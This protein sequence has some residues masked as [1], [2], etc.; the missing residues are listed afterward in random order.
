MGDEDRDS[1]SRQ[2]RIAEYSSPTPATA[3]TPAQPTSN[4]E[5]GSE[6]AD[7]EATG[8]TAADT[9]GAKL[10]TDA[11]GGNETSTTTPSDQSH[12]Q[13]RTNERLVEQT[14][15]TTTP[16]RASQ[17]QQTLSAELKLGFTDRPST[18]NVTEE[19][20]EARKLD[21]IITTGRYPYVFDACRFGF[22][23]GHREE[24]NYQ[25]S[26]DE[27]SLPVHFLDNDYRDS[28]LDR[29]VERVHEYQPEVA[30]I[31]DI[32]DSGELDRHLN[33][34][35]SLW[36]EYPNMELVIVPKTEDVLHEIPDKFVAGYPN[37]KSDIKGSDIA[38]I[39]EWRSISNGIHILG[40]TPLE[41]HDV[42]V[43]LTEYYLAGPSPANIVGLDSNNMW[44]HAQT[45]GDYVDA[46]GGWHRNL[47]S[48]GADGEYHP[49]RDL[50]IYSLLNTKHYWISKGVWP[51]ETPADLALRESL[52]TTAN[53]GR[54]GTSKQ[55][56]PKSDNRDL[57]ELAMTP[58]VTQ[59]R[60][61]SHLYRTDETIAELIEPLS[62]VSVMLDTGWQPDGTLTRKT[63]YD[64]P[65]KYRLHT[66]ACPGCGANVTAEPRETAGA[67][68]RLHAD[69]ESITVKLTSY[70]HYDNENRNHEESI[71]QSGAERLT[72]ASEWGKL[73]LFCSDQC[74]SSTE[75][76]GQNQIVRDREMQGH[77]AEGE[78]IATFE[79]ELW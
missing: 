44:N 26:P 39:Q 45:W 21:W 4:Q 65:E 58:S 8:S 76:R 61:N 51:G 64:I 12:T 60:Q 10:P 56:V 23:I 32:Y 43:D 57:R 78:V 27:V 16:D 35:E 24:S 15:Q 19:V 50:M 9:E 66:T 68:S 3:Q 38:S 18:P 47:R 72:P 46:T 79:I 36:A 5:T 25:W 28:D 53:L 49:K 6:T 71:A 34:A 33:A 29:F 7:G 67:R 31:G 17:S 77:P 2:E 69:Q 37:G 11:G 14:K 41:A 52:V 55:T 73:V 48:V 42:I 62:P 40:G 63:D 70:G 30:V 1:Q 20:A 22:G 75:Y 59:D 74:R 13:P 54:G